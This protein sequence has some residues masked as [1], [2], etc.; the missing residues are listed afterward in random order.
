MDLRWPQWGGFETG[1]VAAVGSRRGIRHGELHDLRR[2]AAAPHRCG[3]GACAVANPRDPASNAGRSCDRRCRCAPSF[4][5]SVVGVTGRRGRLLRPARSRHRG[6]RTIRAVAIGWHA[7]RARLQRAAAKQRSERSEPQASS[8]GPPS[9]GRRSAQR[10]AG[11][12]RFLLGALRVRRPRARSRAPRRRRLLEPSQEGH[13]ARRDPAR[14]ATRAHEPAG[15]RPSSPGGRAPGGERIAI[16]RDALLVR[17]EQS[18][19]SGL[20]AV[21]AAGG[22]DGS[23]E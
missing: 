19:A 11:E 8:V 16:S 15:S 5:V 4:Y 18:R 14:A 20:S 22:V 13:R 1:V 7:A 10:A 3:P 17:I 21:A 23:G 9:A 2:E 6:H 12:R